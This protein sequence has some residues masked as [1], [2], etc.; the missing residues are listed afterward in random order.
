MDILVT[1]LVLTGIAE[2]SAEML[3]K[4]FISYDKDLLE[5]T[6]NAIRI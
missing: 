1:A 2:L 5:M 3:A 4:T 6:T